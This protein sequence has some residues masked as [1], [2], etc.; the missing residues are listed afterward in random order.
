MNLDL[1]ANPIAEK[2]G[3]K[4]KVFGMFP[5]LQVRAYLI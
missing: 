4:E 3:Y 1:N 5:N 2:D